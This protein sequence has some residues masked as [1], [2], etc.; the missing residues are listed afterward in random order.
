[1][2]HKRSA[3]RHEKQCKHNPR[4]RACTTCAHQDH[5][6]VGGGGWDEPPY[7]YIVPVCNSPD[8]AEEDDHF[9]DDQGNPYYVR[10]HCQHWEQS[11]AGE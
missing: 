10:R 1:M 4:V 2:K 6:S 5:E 3:V 8:A 9:F 7:E 11:K